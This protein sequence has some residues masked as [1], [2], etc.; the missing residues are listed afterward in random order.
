MYQK[1]LMSQK[2]RSKFEKTVYEQGTKYR[3][4]LDYEPENSHLSYNR[5]SKYIP[6]FRL[7]NGI[8]VECKGYFK[9][10][11]R[12]KMLRVREQNPGVDI[13][14]VF[15]RSNNKLTKAKN[16]KM[17]WQWA[18]QHGFKWAEGKIPTKWWAEKGDKS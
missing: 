17:Y 2:F 7:P 3:R 4:K 13:R 18:E 6:D 8:L 11:D 12:T 5:P 14:F 1:C 16:S 10:A 15:Q 9:S